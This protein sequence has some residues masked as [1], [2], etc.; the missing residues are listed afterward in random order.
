MLRFDSNHS[1]HLFK[2]EI[3]WGDAVSRRGNRNSIRFNRHVA[4]GEGG[5]AVLAVQ[6]V[7]G[8]PIGAV[9]IGQG[10]GLCWSLQLQRDTIA[11][12]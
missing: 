2:N 5:E 1:I 10:L 3:R 11:V 6:Q 7:V 12:R 4:K 9:E 8:I